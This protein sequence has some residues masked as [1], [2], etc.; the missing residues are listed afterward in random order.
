MLTIRTYLIGLG[1]EGIPQGGGTTKKKG[2]AHPS[3]FIDTI[4]T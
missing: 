4:D 3:W 2:G 1:A